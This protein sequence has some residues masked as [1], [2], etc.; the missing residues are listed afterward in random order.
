MAPKSTSRK[1]TQQAQ[2]SDAESSG[3]EAAQVQPRV[4]EM[5]KNVS[6]SN[7]IASFEVLHWLTMSVEA[8]QHSREAATARPAIRAGYGARPRRARRDCDGGR[9]AR[10]S[11]V[12]LP[13]PDAGP[14]TDNSQFCDSQRRPRPSARAGRAPRTDRGADCQ[15]DQGA[16]AGLQWCESGVAGCGAGEAA[17]ST[18][19]RDGGAC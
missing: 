15:G 2:S 17:G 12:N 6:P 18:G 5:A 10:V 7:Q 3:A 1:Q 4:R 14:L 9:G 11:P 16:R 13:D 19:W 8:E